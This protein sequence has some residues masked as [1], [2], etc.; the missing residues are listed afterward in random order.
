SLKRE[1]L[2]W[3]Y[4]HYNHDLPATTIRSGD[5]K[6]IKRYGGDKE[7]ELFNLK[8]DISETTDL[9][10]TNPAK[11]RELNEK[12]VAWLRHT[13]A[14]MPTKNPNWTGDSSEKKKIRLG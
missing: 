7:F 11:V 6:L 2:F 10:L 13:N 8:D 9:A 5:W 3:H 4:P 1:A 12:L 14:K